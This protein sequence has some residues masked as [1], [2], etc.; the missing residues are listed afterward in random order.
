MK[1]ST[2]ISV[3]GVALCS[4]LFGFEPQVASLRIRGR[5]PEFTFNEYLDK[6]RAQNDQG[7]LTDIITSIA[8]PGAKLGRFVNNSFYSE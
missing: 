5:I 3:G 7:I 8:Y 2:L 4:Y 6:S 1:K